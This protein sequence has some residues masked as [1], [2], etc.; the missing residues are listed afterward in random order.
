MR[1]RKPN[2]LRIPLVR[3]AVPP[4]TTSS[5]GGLNCKAMAIGMSSTVTRRKSMILTKEIN[6]LEN[7]QKKQTNHT[8]EASTSSP[9]AIS[10]SDTLTM[11]LVMHTHPV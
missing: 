7:G 11:V 9:M 6:I 3:S 2:S 10:P 5:I 8:A 4:T 1:R